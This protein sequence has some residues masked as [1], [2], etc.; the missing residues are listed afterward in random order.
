MSQRK[1]KIYWGFPV[2]KEAASEEQ[3]SK[4]SS[5]GIAMLIAIFM[6]AMMMLFMSDILV[7]STVDV[8]LSVA[9]RDNLKSEYMAKSG[10]NMGLFLISTDLAIDSTMYE[11]QGGMKPS[12]SYADIWALMN[13]FPIGGETLEMVSAIQEGFGLSNIKDSDVLDKLK[14]FDGQFVLRVE[15]EAARININF[16]AQSQA[17]RCL[18]VMKSLL[19]CPAE[20]EYLE[21]KKLDADELIGLIKDWADVDQTPEEGTMVSSEDDPYQNRTPRVRPKN[22]PYDTLEELKMIPGWDDDLHRIFSPYLTVYPIPATT[23]HSKATY[24]NINTIDRALLGCLIPASLNECAEKSAIAMDRRQD[25]GALGSADGVKQFLSQS[26]C[27]TDQQKTQLFTYRSDVYRLHVMGQVG[28]QTV[29]LETVVQRGVPDE[30]KRR[31]GFKGAYRY[32]YWKML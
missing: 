25:T 20:Q 12:D 13:D 23:V 18:P 32:L 7:N 21:R 4:E 24:L 1:W 19:S 29:R 5:R 3:P 26:F 8:R 9:A 10:A 27:T 28:D 17:V 11:L 6:T 16:C 30:G 22:A 2:A 14:L 31:D 15:D